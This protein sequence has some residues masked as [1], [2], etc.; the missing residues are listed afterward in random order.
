LGKKYIFSLAGF[1][2]IRDLNALFS[3][4]NN[5]HAI[6]WPGDRMGNKGENIGLD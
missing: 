4:V 6:F 1:K 3:L 5:G 2:Y